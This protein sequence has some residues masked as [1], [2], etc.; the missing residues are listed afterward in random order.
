MRVGI[1]LTQKV[2]SNE[3]IKLVVH[4]L[5]LAASLYECIDAQHAMLSVNKELQSIATD[6]GD[7]A[8][9]AALA[10]VEVLE[11]FHGGIVDE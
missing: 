6:V 8:V 1:D 10:F 3:A 4:H 7:Y 11:S 9:N 2:N 5:M